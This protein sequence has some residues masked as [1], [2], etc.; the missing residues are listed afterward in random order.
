[1][2]ETEFFTK[3]IILTLT[4]ALKQRLQGFADERGWHVTAAVRYFIEAGLD[5]EVR[6]AELA[7]V[8][9]NCWPPKA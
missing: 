2:T 6:R 1:M 8:A 4:P 9:G 3:S 5:G 7:E